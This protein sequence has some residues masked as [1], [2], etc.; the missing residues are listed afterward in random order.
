MD[1]RDYQ[2]INNNQIGPDINFA[3]I[4]FR[5]RQAVNQLKCKK[6]VLVIGC[7]N[8]HDCEIF[9]KEG[10]TVFG[11]DILFNR[12]ISAKK[13]CTNVF[14]GNA[15]QLP[16]SERSFDCVFAGEF[17]EH[18]NFE[19]GI[20]FFK[21]TNR[22]LKKGGLLFVTTPNPDFVKIRVK[23][24]QMIRGAHLSSYSPRQLKRL[25]SDLNYHKIR[26]KGSGRVAALIGDY[27][28]ILSLY[29]SYMVIA[30]KNA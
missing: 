23:K 2:K 27:F 7:A 9:L 13:K 19:H 25:L 1:S 18:L 12:L 24:I 28:P 11:T 4:V 14:C 30:Q 20:I 16:F 5:A 21:E 10:H 15:I 22:L 8:G 26:V 17:I 3:P 6:Q 29:G